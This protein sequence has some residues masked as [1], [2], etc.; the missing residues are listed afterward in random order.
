[1]NIYKNMDPKPHRR[2]HI[3]NMKRI[4]KRRHINNKQ[5]MGETN[6]LRATKTISIIK[7]FWRDKI[8][9]TCWLSLIMRLPLN[10]ISKPLLRNEF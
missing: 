7:Y 8:S 10:R 4:E 1:M 5:L 2:G 3:S 6:K 9:E